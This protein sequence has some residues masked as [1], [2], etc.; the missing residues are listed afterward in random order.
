MNKMFN[1]GY[2]TAKEENRKQ[3]EARENAG[4]K[5]W[6]FFLKGDG[7]EADI[8]FLTEEPINFW[9]HSIKT[10]VQGKERYESV[11]C[12][13]ENCPHCAD[14]KPSYK[15]AFLIYDLRDFTYKDKDGKEQTQKGAVRLY[16]AGAKI[17]T[18][19]DRLSKRYGL[20]SR[21]YTISRSGTGTATSYMFDRGD[22]QSTLSP[23]KI[24]SLL[25][26]KLAESYDGTMES[27]YNIVTEQLTM[28]V[29]D[30]VNSVE[31]KSVTDN[32]KDFVDVPD[33]PANNNSTN[34]VP[35]GNKPKP[36]AKKLFAKKHNKGVKLNAHK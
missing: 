9:E 24:K 34:E 8:R 1:R 23:E 36:T 19:L 18:Q 20:T 5:L 29:E 10:Y 33:M 14:S 25:P 22:E 26:D 15:G 7:D 35:W 27:L 11:I 30:S 2:D 28:G 4:K 12:T 32:S 31:D 3:E 17:V 16:V 6:R 13:G 21:V